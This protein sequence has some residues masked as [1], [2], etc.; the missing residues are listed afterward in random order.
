MMHFGNGDKLNRGGKTCSKG[1]IVKAA[2]SHPDDN[3]WLQI[4][5]QTAVVEMLQTQ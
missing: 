3:T 2:D 1:L 5:R 4:I